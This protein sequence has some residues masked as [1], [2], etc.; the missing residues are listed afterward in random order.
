LKQLQLIQILCI[1]APAVAAVADLAEKL[2]ELTAS[3]RHWIAPK[4]PRS[5]RRGLRE[6]EN[7]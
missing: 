7:C 1:N 5:G 4:R 3:C 2:P 6:V